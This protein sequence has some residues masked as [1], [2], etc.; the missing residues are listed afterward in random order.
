AE[1]Q[2]TLTRSADRTQATISFEFLDH[3]D[4]AIIQVMHTGTEESDV[5]VEGLVINGG[6][7]KRLGWSMRVGCAIALLN[8]MAG[9]VAGIYGT[10]LATGTFDNRPLA[11]ID[12]CLLPL[13]GL[14]CLF[15]LWETIFKRPPPPLGRY[16]WTR[17]FYKA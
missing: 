11:V 13:A 9:V 6:R 17:P 14:W 10:A 1:N 5:A 16:R 8:M 7:P 3:G 4:G 15:R 12:W 2:V